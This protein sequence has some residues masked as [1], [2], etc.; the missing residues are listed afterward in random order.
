MAPAQ[1]LVSG[2]TFWL[3]LAPLGFQSPVWTCSVRI[4]ISGFQLLSWLLCDCLAPAQIPDPVFWFQIP[5]WTSLPS[6]LNFLLPALLSCGR[7]ASAQ[8][9]VSG[10]RFLFGPSALASQ[11]PVSAGLSCDCRAPAWILSSGFRFQILV[12]MLRFPVAVWA[13]VRL[14]GSSMDSGFRLQRLACT[15]STRICS[16]LSLRF[17][18]SG[19]RFW[20][21][22]G[23]FASQLPVSSFKRGSRAIARL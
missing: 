19:I 10:F 14:P 15:C 6:H 16:L 8:I 21:A 18:V 13:L 1:I 3:G 2:F 12:W 5:V 9:P 23:L 11:F 20:Y 4:S 17:P 22:C 7:P